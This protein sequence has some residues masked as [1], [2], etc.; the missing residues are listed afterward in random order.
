MP[1]TTTTSEPPASPSPPPPPP[2]AET[3]GPR[4]TRLSELFSSALAHT[5]KTCSYNNFA[6]CF[7]TPAKYVP[8]SLQ[9]VWKQLNAKIEELA[10]ARGALG[11]IPLSRKTDEEIIGVQNEFEDILHERSVVSNLN[12]LDRL[13]A[14]ARKR[15]DHA[16]DGEVPIPP[17]TLPPSPLYNAHL[18]PFLSQTQ[19]SLNARLQT[20]QSQN[21]QLISSIT[22]QRAEIERLIG[23]VEGVVTDLE[24]AVGSLGDVVGSGSDGIGMEVLEGEEALGMTRF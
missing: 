8:G 15:K 19:S 16:I 14:E 1:G 13:I 9:A 4:A 21:A 18:A 23:G 6:A 12:E 5:L 24:R 7:P 22:E 2:I 3:P 10:K 11:V 17:H 20:T